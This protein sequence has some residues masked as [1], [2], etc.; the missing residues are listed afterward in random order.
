MCS[1]AETRIFAYNLGMS[2][3]RAMMWVDP[4]QAP[5]LKRVLDRA[6]IECIGAGSPD[7]ARTG[8][9]ASDLG[10]APIDDLR[11]ALSTLNG[12]LMILANPGSF[13]HQ[14]HDADLDALKAAHAR[15]LCIATLEAIPSAA[16]EIAGTAFAESLHTGALNELVR[17]MP[18]TRHAPMIVELYSVLETFAPIRSCAITLGVPKAFGSLG[19]RLFD[20]MDLVRSL[21]G[22]PNIIDA[23][24]IS[25]A[26]GRGLHPLPG[27]SLSNLSGEFTLNLR[28][29]DGRCAAMF[30]SDQVGSSTIT[31][32]LL[33]NEGLITLDADGFEWRNR[34]GEVIDSYTTPDTS[35]VDLIEIALG[36][37][38]IEL[39]SGVGPK[40]AP[41]DYPGVLSMTH[42][43]LLSTR[44]G[45]GESPRAVEHLLLSM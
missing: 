3:A 32:S 20:A 24:Y 16:H 21:I 4:E 33:S 34:N 25:P 14:S 35:G 45:Q 1:R 18:L 23:A 22:V 8:Q 43:T 12:D 37:Q 5:V 10:C 30:L 13:A 9:V 11:H 15:N 28:F 42:S 44:T 39:C 2:K 6:E 41:I 26:A 29:S 19:A 38:L 36:E 40:R 17:F 27:Q 31:M 7:A